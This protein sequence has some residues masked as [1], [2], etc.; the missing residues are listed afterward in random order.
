MSLDRFR[1]IMKHLYFCYS[2]HLDQADKYVK[3][4]I[5]FHKMYERFLKY[6]PMEENHNI[7]ET[8]VP[9]YGKHS[10]KQFICVKPHIIHGDTNFGQVALHQD[11]I[12]FEHYQEASIALTEYKETGLESS[13]ILKYADVLQSRYPHLPFHPFFDIFFTF[14]PLLGV[15]REKRLGESGTIRGHRIKN[16]L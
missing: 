12:W 13:I 15:L 8:M 9:Y 16:V 11:V 6:A 4:R 14:L 1:F 5:L 10:C 2:N 7:D 3:F